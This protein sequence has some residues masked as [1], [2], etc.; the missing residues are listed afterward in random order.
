[1]SARSEGSEEALISRLEELL[2]NREE[3]WPDPQA[4]K[5][6]HSL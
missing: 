4:A 1:M 3:N 2:R 5:C 6:L